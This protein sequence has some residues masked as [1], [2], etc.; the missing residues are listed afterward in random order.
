MVRS[1]GAGRAQRGTGSAW[2]TARSPNPPPRVDL[3][4]RISRARVR[5]APTRRA[6][7]A[8]AAPPRRPARVGLIDQR[9]AHAQRDKEKERESS[10][11]AADAAIV[12]ATTPYL[13][14]PPAPNARAPAFAP[15][16]IGEA[17][18][19]RLERVGAPLA[20]ARDMRAI[21]TNAEDLGV[22]KV[23]HRRRLL[24]AIAALDDVD[25]DLIGTVERG[26]ACALSRARG[27]ARC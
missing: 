17:P 13:P 23:G 21:K 15:D 16:E 24:D 19:R 1:G 4:A 11:S 7:P 22:T 12:L 27:A 9:A 3:I 26:R 25:R 10:V 8:A 20:R 6:R 2:T 18:P 5:R 14:S